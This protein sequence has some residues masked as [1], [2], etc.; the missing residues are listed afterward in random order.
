MTGSPLRRPDA[1]A[2]L[3]VLTPARVVVTAVHQEVVTQAAHTIQAHLRAPHTDEVDGLVGDLGSR[4]SPATCPAM[5]SMKTCR[6][7]PSLLGEISS[8]TI[9]VRTLSR[10]LG[11]RC[12]PMGRRISWVALVSAAPGRPPP[13]DDR[14]PGVCHRVSTAAGRVTGAA[15]CGG[16]QQPA[17][18]VHVEDPSGGP[19]SRPG[20]CRAPAAWGEALACVPRGGVGARVWPPAPGDV[21]RPGP[22]SRA[23][24]ARRGCR[25]RG[26]APLGGAP[27]SR[28]ARPWRCWRRHPA[29]CHDSGT[30][31]LLRS[32]RGSAG[33]PRAA[34]GAGRARRCT[35]WRRGARRS[36]SWQTVLP[37]ST[38]GKG[39]MWSMVRRTGVSH[40]G[41]C[42]QR[43]ASCVTQ[44][45]RDRRMWYDAAA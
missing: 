35:C 31:T 25:R 8:G 19:G 22:G 45:T 16:L 13:H 42:A 39:R 18:P 32:P 38:V 43:G 40:D 3:A 17:P 10:T 21:D 34:C 41:R 11:R 6:P 27:V 5:C 44:A 15:A 28:W 30:R 33:H 4:S 1:L 12:H 2:A 23:G 37:W 24:P 36:A 7:F 14:P 26:S 9:T 20:V 29:A